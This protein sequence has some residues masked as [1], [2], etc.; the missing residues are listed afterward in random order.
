ML[1]LVMGSSDMKVYLILVMLCG[2]GECHQVIHGRSEYSC[3]ERRE[4]EIVKHVSWQSAG[5]RTGRWARD[6]QS[7]GCAVCSFGVCV[8][9]AVSSLGRAFF[10]FCAFYLCLSSCAYFKYKAPGRLA[11]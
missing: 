4:G 1:G 9:F 11:L 8:L 2:K 10:H 7:A 6:W 5:L 3:D